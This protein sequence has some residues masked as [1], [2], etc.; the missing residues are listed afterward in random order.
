M[1]ILR[2][3]G[4][5]V[6]NEW[7]EIYD[8]Y[9]IDCIT[10]KK[11]AVALAELADGD[12]LHI[13]L[14]SGGGHVMAGQEIYALLRGRDDVD[15]E[16]ESLAASAA[17][18][19]AMAAP[20]KMLP[21]ALLMVHRAWMSSGGNKNDLERDARALSA[22]DEALSAAYCEKSGMSRD[23]ALSLM[24]AETWLTAERALELRLID[25]ISERQSSKA[26]ASAGLA[27]TE[28][29]VAEYKRVM[30]QKKEAEQREAEELKELL[31]ELEKSGDTKGD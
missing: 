20:C 1:A 12:T 29:M 23:E 21:T 18:V 25:G 30:Q 8:Y 27:V 3:N 13:K 15:I 16:V 7:G 14:N 24:D 6:D 22:V 5:V 10:P 2:L 4:D 9:G 11:T 17:S 28:D 19:I 31:A 26:A